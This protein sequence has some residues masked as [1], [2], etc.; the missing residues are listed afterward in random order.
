MR[1]ALSLSIGAD[2]GH[3]YTDRDLADLVGSVRE[4]EGRRGLLRAG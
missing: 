1:G 4:L 3:R 2:Q